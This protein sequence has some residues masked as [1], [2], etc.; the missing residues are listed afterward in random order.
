MD[1]TLR[2]DLH[3]RTETVPD[4]SPAAGGGNGKQP[5]NAAIGARLPG[6]RAE[7]L[8]QLRQDGTLVP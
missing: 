8:A 1:D 7:A 5:V 4:L 2:P 6:S 3:Q